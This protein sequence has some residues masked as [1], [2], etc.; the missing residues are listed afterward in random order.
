MHR[1]GSMCHLVNNFFL[2]ALRFWLSCNCGWVIRCFREEQFR[3]RSMLF[4]RADDKQAGTAYLEAW[5][6]MGFA[7]DSNAN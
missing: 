4:N 1:S 3:V 6:S 2:A 7:F 5:K